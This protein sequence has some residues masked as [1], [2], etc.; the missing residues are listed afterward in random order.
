MNK[1]LAKSQG[2]ALRG[3]VSSLRDPWVND[4]FLIALVPRLQPVNE[5]CKLL[6]GSGPGR[7]DGELTTKNEEPGTL[8]SQVIISFPA[9]EAP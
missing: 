6:I 4:F 1:K 5:R 3:H 7:P 8:N 9:F 2:P